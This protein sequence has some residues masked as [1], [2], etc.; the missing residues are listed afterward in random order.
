MQTT[1]LAITV[2]ALLIVTSVEIVGFLSMC[3][4]AYCERQT[5]GFVQSPTIELLIF[6]GLQIPFSLLVLYILL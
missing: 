4:L 3:W 1:I 2:F 6:L 5:Q